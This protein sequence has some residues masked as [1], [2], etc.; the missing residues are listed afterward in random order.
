MLSAV[1][2]PVA[3]TLEQYRKQFV[4]RKRASGVNY[5]RYSANLKKFIEASAK[6]FTDTCELS[7][8]AVLEWTAP[9]KNESPK[10]RQMRINTVRA[11]AEYL[12]ARGIPAYIPQR[13]RYSAPDYIPHVFSNDEMK[14]LINAIDTRP[15]KVRGLNNWYIMPVLFRTLYACGLRVSEALRLRICDVNLEDGILTILGTKFHKDRLVPI[16]KDFI[17]A[18]KSY[19]TQYLFDKDSD[20]PF[21]PTVKGTHYKTHSVYGAFRKSL[22]DAGIPHG[23]KGRGPRVHDIRHT[24]AVHCLRKWVQAGDDLQAAIPYLAAYMGHT[25]FRHTQVYLQLTSDMYPDVVSKVEQMFD[26]FPKW[27]G[28]DERQEGSYETD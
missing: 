21:F 19:A 20:S 7:K 11:F 1:D 17:P 4:D 24:F 2:A 15:G 28:N 3:D 13:A 5:D 8:E 26:V 23:G 12:A 10:T 9:R 18:L 25:H 16:H 22:W 6:Y 14:R 27:K